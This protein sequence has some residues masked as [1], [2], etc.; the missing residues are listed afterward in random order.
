MR[1]TK[2]VKYEELREKYDYIIGWGTPKN[3]F[4]SRYNPFMYKLDFVINGQN[5]DV[6]KIICGIKVYGIDKLKEVEES[7]VCVVIAPNIEYEIIKQIEKY[8]PGADTIVARL[9]EAE[10]NEN[11]YS[12]D[13]EDIIMY[14]IMKKLGY[15]KFTYM[16]I[17]VCHPVIR[18]NTYLFYENSKSKGVLVEPN[19][20]MVELIKEYRPEDKVIVCGTGGKNDETLRYYYSKSAPGLNTF[21]KEIAK[22]RNILDNYCEIPIRNI[23]EIIEENFESFPDVIDIDSE[24]MDIE[25]LKNINFNKYKIKIICIENDS[26][27][28]LD[29]LQKNNYIHCMTTKENNIFVLEEELNK[30]KECEY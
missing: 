10:E 9:V 29:F 22:Q 15:E 30:Y 2:K 12:T 6:G 27:E 25:I 7:K 21:K 23:N 4:K 11:T 8:I 18:N 24:G 1:Y 26:E 16:D 28:A 17:G 3:E 20:L 13:C 14:D 19:P 5:R